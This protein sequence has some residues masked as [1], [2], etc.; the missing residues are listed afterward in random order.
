MTIAARVE[1]ALG[2]SVQAL[3]PL[4]G[5]DLSQVLRAD[6]GGGGCVVAKTGLNVVAEAQ[7]LTALRDAGA[8][9]PEVL[10]A[11]AGLILLEHLEERT[12]SRAG[13]GDLGSRLRALHDVT[14]PDYGWHEDHAFGSV[15]IANT[16]AA[17]WPAFWA[18]RRL[19]A[20][21]EAVPGPIVRR[22]EAL[23]A[24][25]PD[26]LPAAPPAALLHGDLWPGNVIFTAGG[27]YLIDPACYHGDA[28][29]DL[30]MV[31]LFGNPPRDFWAG[32]GP[33]QE[34]AERRRPVYQLWPAL[35]HL[36]LFG[37]G[38]AGMVEGLLDRLRA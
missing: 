1:A 29:V 17:D 19:L 13:W 34:G 32:Y 2:R 16:A 14:G 38:Y 10:H 12:P 24:R 33:T 5:G 36:R 27:A 6:L 21:A 28:E 3:S 22:V 15:A 9:V 26:L 20:A 8:P 23:A 35:V 31:T 37:A 30:A 11:E 18:E 7:M 25:L 4:H